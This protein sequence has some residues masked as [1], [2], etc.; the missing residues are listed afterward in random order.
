MFTSLYSSPSRPTQAC[1]YVYVYINPPTLPNE[2]EFHSSASA[3]DEYSVIR[4]QSLLKAEKTVDKLIAR[5]T[6]SV[7]VY[8][9]EVNLILI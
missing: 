9:C 5:A 3:F 6:K 4:L 1:H 7:F 2:I 8:W